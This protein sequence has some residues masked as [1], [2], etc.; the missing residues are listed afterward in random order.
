MMRSKLGP[1]SNNTVVA[2]RQWI[3]RVRQEEL[4]MI[5]SY[6]GPAQERIVAARVQQQKNHFYPTSKQML[7][8]AAAHHQPSRTKSAARDSDGFDS[9]SQVSVLTPKSRQGGPSSHYGGS[10]VSYVTRKSSAA[11]TTVST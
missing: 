9:V 11:A 4:N 10:S 6:A 5:D 2:D 7:K 3:R 1:S 8:N